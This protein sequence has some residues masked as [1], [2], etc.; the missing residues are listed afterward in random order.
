MEELIQLDKDLLLYLH[1]L[2]SPTWDPF[3]LFM[4]EKFYQI[5]LYVVLLIFFFRYLGVKGTL[6][7]LLVVAALITAT[8]Q[9]S[10][11]AKNVLFQRPRPCRAVGVEEFMRSIEVYCGRFGYFS[12]HASSSMGLAFFTGLTL[13]HR[14]KYIFPFMVVWA[15]IVSYSRIYLGVH[16]PAD[17][18]TG[19]V[20]GIL[21]GSAAYKLHG[22]LI[23]R[24]TSYSHDEMK[25]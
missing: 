22:Y 25:P 15:C 20:M 13:Q 3:W 1:N 10:S 11:I 24:F 21:L 17:V 12:G 23:N 4:T 18:I 19:M 7:T 16:Y 2:G 5:P 14:L 9:F 8:D 6:I